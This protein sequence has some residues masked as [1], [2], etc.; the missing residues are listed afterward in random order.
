MKLDLKFKGVLIF[1]W[2]LL[3]QA[4]RSFC[5]ILR[6]SLLKSLAP[7]QGK[8]LLHGVWVAGPPLPGRQV[9]LRPA[10]E[11]GLEITQLS[12]HKLSKIFESQSAE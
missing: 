3:G 11:A 8:G 6:S 9:G 1:G 2:D 5:K 7:S 10:A 12:A 4:L